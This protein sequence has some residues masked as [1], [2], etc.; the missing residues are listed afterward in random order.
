MNIHASAATITAVTNA[1]LDYMD[2][3]GTLRQ[4]EFE[5]CRSHFVELINSANPNRQ[6]SRLYIEATQSWKYIAKRNSIGDPPWENKNP[7]Y[8]E[9]YTD[10]PTRFEFPQTEAGMSEYYR[11]RA[12]VEQVGWLTWDGS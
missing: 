7:A 8:I 1:G 4:I 10:P 5:S 2:G 3:A 11:L 12:A 6:D 9:F